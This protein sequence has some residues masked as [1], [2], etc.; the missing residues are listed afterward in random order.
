M[1]QETI[2]TLFIIIGALAALVVAPSTA[3]AA[4]P[5][6]I[7]THGVGNP[8]VL[9]GG[10]AE[11][12]IT[13]EFAWHLFLPGLDS[14][15]RPRYLD[16]LEPLKAVLGPLMVQLPSSVDAAAVERLE[17]VFDAVAAR[18]AI[19]IEVRHPE[20]FATPSL[21]EPCLE[22]Y[23]AGREDLARIAVKNHHNGTLAPKS[24]LKREIT[25]EDACILHT[26][27]VYTKQVMWLGIKECRIEPVMSFDVLLGK[28]RAAGGDTFHPSASLS[29]DIERP[30]SNC[31]TSAS[32]TR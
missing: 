12:L 27:A 6:A 29:I 24:F 28:N 30:D 31:S 14:V 13:R 16:A 7:T 19:V 3:V 9:A 21:L 17:P 11:A 18:H 15:E 23:G 32:A 20:F 25:I 8:T 1:D 10:I 2:S 4:H 22:K 26:H 5:T